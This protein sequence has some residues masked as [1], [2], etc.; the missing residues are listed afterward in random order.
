MIGFYWI[1]P[2]NGSWSFSLLPCVILDYN[3]EEQIRTMEIMWFFWGFGFQR[4]D[5]E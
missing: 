5:R 4:R 1:Y 2:S 3:E